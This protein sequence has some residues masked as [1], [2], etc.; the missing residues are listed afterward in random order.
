MLFHYRA[1]LLLAS[2]PLED[3]FRLTF[4][5]GFDCNGQRLGV[6]QAS[7]GGTCHD[8]GALGSSTTSVLVVRED[9]D[10]DDDIVVFY[11]P[12][13]ACNPS[14]AIS[15]TNVG[16]V[17]TIPTLGGFNVISGE[18]KRRDAGFESS[19]EVKQLR[20]DTLGITHGD[21]FESG[22]E[23][24][25]WQMVAKDTFTGVKPD[26]WENSFHIASAAPLQFSRDYPFNF[27][28]YDLHHGAEAKI[29]EAT[30]AELELLR[31]TS[32][33][34][35]HQAKEALANADICR[36]IRNCGYSIAIL[37]D[38]YFPAQTERFVNAVR[39]AAPVGQRI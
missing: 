21:F 24:W 19:A 17:N 27:T 32:S 35:A 26:Q 31:G 33:N 20:S 6:S 25:R 15:T 8:P 18:F 22:G 5:S 7:L 4:Y 14:E 39:A 16:C 23:L 13:A 29:P 11:P 2:I 9:G 37:S 34:P 38:Y 30:P 1:A 12:D 36:Q 3:A 28:E 10:G